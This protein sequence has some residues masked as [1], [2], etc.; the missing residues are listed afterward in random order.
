[1]HYKGGTFFVE[2]RWRDLDALLNPG[3]VILAVGLMVSALLID[4]AA[5][6]ARHAEEPGT[7][8]KDEPCAVCPECLGQGPRTTRN[9]CPYCLGTGFARG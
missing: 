8:G 2:R 7:G 1:M 6:R 3:A 9:V 5:R 4:R